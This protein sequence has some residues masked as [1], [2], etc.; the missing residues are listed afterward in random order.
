[1]AVPELQPGSS[2]AGLNDTAAGQPAGTIRKAPPSIQS[3]TFLYQFRV[4]YAVAAHVTRAPL[5]YYGAVSRYLVK[6]HF[7]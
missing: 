2:S 1:V 7:W 5:R 3:K 6:E 4:S